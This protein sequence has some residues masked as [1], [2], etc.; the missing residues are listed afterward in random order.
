M[1]LVHEQMYQSEVLTDLDFTQYIENLGNYLFKIYGVNTKKIS[2]NIDI[3]EAN[4]DFNR[5]ILL[6]LIVN[7]LISNSL[8]YAFPDDL[9]GQVKVKLDSEDDYFILT[10]SDNGVGLPKNFRLRQT[11]SLGLQLVQALT[12]QLKGSIKIDRRKGTRFKIK[13]PN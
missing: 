7:E 12:N 13:F 1:A 10:A 3:K 5:A 8:K 9:A 6:G 11:K 4:I 2:M